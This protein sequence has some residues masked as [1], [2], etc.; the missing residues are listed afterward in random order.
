MVL[1]VAAHST[2]PLWADA[3]QPLPLS[4]AVEAAKAATEGEAPPVEPSPLSLLTAALDDMEVPRL[5]P[6]RSGLD[7]PLWVERARAGPLGEG[8]DLAT[9]PIPLFRYGKNDRAAR[10]ERLRARFVGACLLAARLA[11]E[12]EV[13]VRFR[14]PL[15]E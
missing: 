9:K 7:L 12:E 15:P 5:V 10:P 4:P 2:T 3:G 1:V 14:I 8:I 13:E 11:A 6:R